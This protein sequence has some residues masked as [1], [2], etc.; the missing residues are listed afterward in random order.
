MVW[1]YLYNNLTVFVHGLVMFTYDLDMFFWKIM[2]YNYKAMNFLN[3]KNIQDSF[4]PRGGIHDARKFGKER[5]KMSAVNRCE[6]GQPARKQQ[7][8]GV[9]H[10]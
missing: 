8:D 10:P 3:G 4:L 6:K 1:L 5:R 2:C 9:E 7:R